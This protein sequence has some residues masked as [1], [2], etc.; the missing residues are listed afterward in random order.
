MMVLTHSSRSHDE[1]L[2]D[3]VG[4]KFLGRYNYM[5]RYHLYRTTFHNEDMVKPLIC[6]CGRRAGRACSFRKGTCPTA[7]AAAAAD[8]PKRKEQTNANPSR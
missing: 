3:Y 5:G 8:S 2:Y 7:L 6:M 1:I 4:I